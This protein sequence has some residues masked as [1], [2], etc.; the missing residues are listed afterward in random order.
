M[1]RLVEFAFSMYLVFL[2]LDLG[3]AYVRARRYKL[4]YLLVKKEQ[5]F[6]HLFMVSHTWTVVVALSLL[7]GV[8]IVGTLWSLV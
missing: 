7:W 6:S 1:E 4:K 3:Q 2:V 8:W 5:T